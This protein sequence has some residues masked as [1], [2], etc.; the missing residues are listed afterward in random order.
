MFNL[1]PKAEKD[2]IRRE[3]RTRL[4]V[5]VLWFFFATMLIASILLLPSY[6]LSTQNEKAA[7]RQSET[8]TKSIKAEE[9]SKFNEVLSGIKSRLDVVTHKPPALYLY[10]L[11]SRIAKERGSGISFEGMTISRE[12]GL[13]RVD[14]GGIAQTRNALVAFQKALMGTGLFKTVEFPV[15]DLAKDGNSAFTLTARGDF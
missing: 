8:I 4:A 13:R 6:F 2:A 3:Y 12:E 7:L 10:E 15:A 11:I 14:I 5:V 9:S 1:L